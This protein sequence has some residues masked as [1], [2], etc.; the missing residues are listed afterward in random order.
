MK[1]PRQSSAP[2]SGIVQ[3]KAKP[4]P[5]KVKLD[6]QPAFLLPPRKA[7]PS[8][9][10][11]DRVLQ[12]PQLATKPHPRH[13]SEPPGSMQHE[14]ILLPTAPRTSTPKSTT[15]TSSLLDSSVLPDHI[16]SQD[17]LFE[18]GSRSETSLSTSTSSIEF[19]NMQGTYDNSRP[20][21][22]NASQ[23]FAQGPGIEVAP[24]LYSIPNSDPNWFDESAGRHL[25]YHSEGSLVSETSE[26]QI[27]DQSAD[28]Y[29]P[30]SPNHTP[31]AQGTSLQTMC[32]SFEE[33]PSACQNHHGRFNRVN[34]EDHHKL[35]TSANGAISQQHGATQS[36]KPLADTRSKEYSYQFIEHVGRTLYYCCR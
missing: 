35:H 14:D 21:S 33:V 31:Y 28:Q 25:T 34:S 23:E 6:I 26:L 17:H 10:S 5:Q 27:A 13:H 3:E 15:P 18:A 4:S 1:L 19:Y 24:S 20:S 29:N 8:T 22:A 2:A 16:P 30:L 32:G 7:Q 9:L 12:V 11:G 36:F